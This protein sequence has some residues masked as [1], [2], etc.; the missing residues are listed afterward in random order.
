MKA[1]KWLRSKIVC[2]L[3]LFGKIRNYKNI[4]IWYCSELRAK[5]KDV[6][7]ICWS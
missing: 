7:Y 2:P 5:D 4:E 1:G 3:G 6:D